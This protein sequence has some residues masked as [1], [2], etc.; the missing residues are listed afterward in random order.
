MKIHNVDN[1]HVTAQQDEFDKYFARAAL[2]LQVDMQDEAELRR[3]SLQPAHRMATSSDSHPR[4]ATSCK[5]PKAKRKNSSSPMRGPNSLSPQTAAAASPSGRNEDVSR[6]SFSSTCSGR[7]SPKNS[8]T[9]GSSKFL[10]VK[11]NSAPHS[12]SNSWKKARR[13]GSIRSQVSASTAQ[14][15]QSSSREEDGN[16]DRRVSVSLEESVCAKLEELKM[17]QADDCYVVRNFS[18]SP[19]G[20]LVNRGDSFKRRSVNSVA[21]SCSSSGAQDISAT[22][23]ELAVEGLDRTRSLSVHSQG[24]STTHSS[25]ETPPVYRVI[26]LGSHGVG[27]TAMVQQFMTSE[28]MGA[29]ET[30]FGNAKYII[31]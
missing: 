6:A 1:R 25:T 15:Q 5:Y 7:H 19:E 20:H 10:E 16:A 24:S 13:P 30:S 23:T 31:L 8:A 29:V 12:R 9:S 17:L 27:K 21:G 26:V 22:A 18:T 4:R 3:A 11:S 2:G 28:F 14:Q